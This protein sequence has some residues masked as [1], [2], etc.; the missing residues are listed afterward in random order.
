MDPLTVYVH[1]QCSKSRAAVT[2]LDD[3]HASFRA[4]NYLESP[5]DAE[6]IGRLVDILIGQPAD[7]IRVDDDLFGQL[8]LVPSDVS[9]R[10]GVI[11]VLV[12]HPELMQR[13][14]AVMGDR[15]VVA[16]PP[17]LVAQ[18]LD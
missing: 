15:A 4:V 5:P 12:A 9:D 6:T 8:G 1:P 7:L 16:R 2:L 13:P 14:L 3:R 11:K 18:L 17:E 10:A